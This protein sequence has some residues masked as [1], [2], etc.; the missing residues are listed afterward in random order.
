[1]SLRKENKSLSTFVVVGN[2]KTI[3]LDLRLPGMEGTEDE[4]H[5]DDLTHVLVIP[6][7]PGDQRSLRV[8]NLHQDV[9]LLDLGLLCQIDRP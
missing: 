1:M 2:G 8:E 3:I 7:C 4:L 5:G 6:Q 9:K